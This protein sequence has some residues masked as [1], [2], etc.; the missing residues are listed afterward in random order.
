[1][2]DMKRLSVSLPDELFEQIQKK[3]Q[4][5]EFCNKPYSEIIR[6]FM[7]LGLEAE[8]NKKEE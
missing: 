4:L 8:R 3:K 2:T 1:M 7:L 6:H 5:K